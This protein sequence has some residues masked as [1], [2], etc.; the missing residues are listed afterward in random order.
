MDLV[1]AYFAYEVLYKNNNYQQIFEGRTFILILT[2]LYPEL[3]SFRMLY[4]IN[5]IIFSHL[6]LGMDY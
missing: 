2:V 4:A 3:Y 5:I 1:V 6:P